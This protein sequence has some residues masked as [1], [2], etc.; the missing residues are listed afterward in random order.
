MRIMWG[1]DK[2]PEAAAPAPAPSRPSVVPAASVAAGSGIRPGVSPASPPVPR[3][4]APEAV[5]EQRSLA[6]VLIEQGHISQGQLEEAIN[7]QKSQGGFLGQILVDL[8]YFDEN[9]LI[10]FLAKQCK[11][12]HLSLLD[13]LI[14]PGLF[15]LIPETVCLE[16]QLLPIDK[17]AK[18]LTV[19]MVNPLDS[20]ALEKIRELNPELRIK[21]ILCAYSH[22][23][24]VVKKLFGEKMPTGAPREMTAADFGLGPKSVERPKSSPAPAPPVA[25]VTSTASAS[26]EAVIAEPIPAPIEAI[27]PASA[28]AA[29]GLPLA[30]FEPDAAP[31]AAVDGNSIVNAFMDTGDTVVPVAAA[32]PP[33]PAP[34]VPAASFMMQEMLDVMRDSMRETY[35]VLT[36]RMELFR[37]LSSNDVA[38]VFASGMST[39]FNAGEVVFNKGD[40]SDELYVVLA[41]K[42]DI[43][44]GDKRIATLGPGDILGEMAWISDEPRSATAVALE[45]ATLVGL[46]DDIFHNL[47]SSEASIQLLMNIILLLSERVRTANQR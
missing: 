24:A 27:S 40:Q 11:I 3:R 41:G 30:R 25:S 26:P 43:R 31:L 22:Y 36:R 34:S 33:A 17:L 44:D 29:A 6:E 20:R 14:D 23:Q 35:E 39:E 1:K 38:K 8:R 12:P 10:T 21:P 42:V 16:Y 37:G 47:I 5:P 13:Y 15:S 46:S 18:N 2:T 28:P 45:P 4:A 32:A 9:S 19:A 7:V